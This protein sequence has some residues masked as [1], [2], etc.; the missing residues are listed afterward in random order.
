MRGWSVGPG[1]AARR[2]LPACI[3]VRARP[4]ALPMLLALVVS[5]LVLA[6]PPA[7]AAGD[8]ERGFRIWLERDLWPDARRMGIRRATFEAAFEGVTPNLSLPDLVLP[9]KHRKARKVKGQAEFIKPPGRYMSEKVLAWLTQKGR[10]LLAAHRTTLQ[11]TA[12]RFGVQPSVVLA[13]WGRETSFGE[14]KLKHD[15]IRALATEAYLGRRKRYFRAELLFALR[16]VEDGHVTLEKM[17]RHR[18][19][20]AG[21]MGLTQFMPSDIYRHAVD[22]DGDARADVWTSVPDALASAA[23]QLRDK[24]WQAGKTWG[25]EVRVPRDFDCALEGPRHARTIREW[26]ALGF[27]RTF[28]RAFL[29]E[30]LDERAFL[31]MPAGIYGPAF[32]MIKNFL[33][34][35]EYNRAD[36]YALFVGHLADRIAGMEGFERPWQPVKMLASDEIKFIQARLNRL[37]YKVGKVDGFL[38]PATR[39]GIGRYQ[40]ARGMR[41]DCWPSRALLED[42]RRSS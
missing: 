5:L 11:R 42:L 39:S 32:L 26:V 1:R 34:F 40:K 24:G 15:P 33:V 21:A 17:R 9:G 2:R 19:S 29:P 20:W 4:L 36:L 25:Y 3:A 12:E 18:A 10:D 8:I 28:D 27:R 7:M 16:L 37:G 31:L 22:F 41:R 14:W 35:K 38:G 6:A 23:K 13:I 30:R